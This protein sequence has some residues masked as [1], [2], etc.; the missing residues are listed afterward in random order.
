MIWF[1]HIKLIPLVTLAVVLSL[2]GQRDDDNNPFDQLFQGAT[3]VINKVLRSSAQPTSTTTVVNQYSMIQPV[4]DGAN[5]KYWKPVLDGA[6]RALD[7]HTF[8]K[9]VKLVVG[10]VC[11]VD[12]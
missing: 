11:V 1:I 4:K 6:G 2:F 5:G 8:L 9:S 12:A 10:F 3:A 7:D